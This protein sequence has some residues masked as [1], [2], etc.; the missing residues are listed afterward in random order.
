MA[1][2][3]KTRMAVL[4]RSIRHAMIGAKAVKS[5]LTFAI[6]IFAASPAYAQAEPARAA[7]AYLHCLLAHTLDEPSGDEE[8]DR[9]DG[10]GQMSPR[11]SC[12]YG[13]MR[14]DR[15]DKLRLGGRGDRALCLPI[16]AQIA[17]TERRPEGFA[18]LS[19]T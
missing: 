6:V 13:R 4:D 17:A 1:R 10:P 18:I 3:D 16:D 14:G 5:Y 7:K 9:E 11:I 8:V 12:L 15:G 2:E 19:V